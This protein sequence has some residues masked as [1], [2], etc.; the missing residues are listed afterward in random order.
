[1]EGATMHTVDWLDQ[2]CELL[3]HLSRTVWLYISR[4]ND[5][6]PMTLTEL[7]DEYGRVNGAIDALDRKYL[8]EAQVLS[9]HHYATVT[10]TAA[11]HR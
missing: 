6:D 3:Q 2:R 7:V 10:E 8:R 5:V 4:I 1:M 9:G 11:R